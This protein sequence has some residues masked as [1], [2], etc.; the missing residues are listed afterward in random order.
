MSTGI[1]R[2]TLI[3]T[4]QLDVKHWHEMITNPTVTD[5]IPDPR[6]HDAYSL[7]LVADSP[8][9]GT[10]K[11]AG[12][13]ANAQHEALIPS[14]GGTLQLRRP[15]VWLQSYSLYAIAVIRSRYYSRLFSSQVPSAS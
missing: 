12:L 11:R 13:D 10:A 1:G 3:V 6:V 7:N 4:S 2:R 8:R 15:T 5:A 9:E 14:M